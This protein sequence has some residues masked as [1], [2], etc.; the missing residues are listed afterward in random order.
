MLHQDSG[1]FIYKYT[2]IYLHELLICK[3]RNHQEEKLPGGS[4][5]VPDGGGI[6]VGVDDGSRRLRKALVLVLP[7]DPVPRVA[8]R[9]FS[10]RGGLGVLATSEADWVVFLTDGQGAPGGGRH[11]RPRGMAK[12]L[13][14]GGARLCERDCDVWR[15]ACVSVC[16][17]E[18]VR[19]C[20]LR[21]D[22]RLRP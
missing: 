16:L 22:A 1:H 17:R 19:D 4:G 5:G 11:P 9:F 3:L 12:G 21:G 2:T 8:A 13:G 7:L 6:S 20:G 15:A 10:M 14:E 18:C